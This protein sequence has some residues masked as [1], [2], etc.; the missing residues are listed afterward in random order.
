MKRFLML[1]LFTFLLFVARDGSYAFSQ[2]AAKAPAA[3]QAMKSPG[4]MSALSGKVVESMNS[5]GY[6]YV[7]ISKA[8][9]T[10][11]VAIPQMNVKVGQDISVRSGM[12]M[13]NF[14]SKTLNRTFESI[15]F[16]SGVINQ[17]GMNSTKKTEHHNQAKPSAKMSVKVDKATGPDAFTVAELY[18]KSGDL[19]K[20]GVVIRGKIVKVSANIMGKNWMHIQDGSGNSSNG[21]NDIIVTSKD[22][23]SV[24]DVVTAKGT[25]YKNKDFGQGYK[26]AVIV[27]DASV[28]K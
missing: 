20:K 12:T 10:I 18:E 3:P 23:L 11:W 26:Y 27:E 28:K 6:T 19:D 15:V 14:N 21:T 8:G 22:L 13:N 24:G 1:F 4:G 2:S 16:S 25:L 9:K 7:N 5:G 17:E